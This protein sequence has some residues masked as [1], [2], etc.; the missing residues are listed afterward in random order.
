MVGFTLAPAGGPGL[1]QPAGWRARE[2]Y[3]P[4]VV[5]TMAAPPCGACLLHGPVALT[6]VLY[7]QSGSAPLRNAQS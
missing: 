6:A 1:G 3:L 7:L 4:V 2:R 5:A